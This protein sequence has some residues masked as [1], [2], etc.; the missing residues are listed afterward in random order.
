[1]DRDRPV[2]PLVYKIGRSQRD[3]V[4]PITFAHIVLLVLVIAAGRNV[5]PVLEN[6]VEP[7]P[8]PGEYDRRQAG[9]G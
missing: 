2:L 3:H 5:G 4:T 8:L 9:I 1:M 7:V 6:P